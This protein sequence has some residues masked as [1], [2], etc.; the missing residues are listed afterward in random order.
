M[1]KM[2]PVTLLAALLLLSNSQLL[3]ARAAV[4]QVRH[5]TRESTPTSTS[6]DHTE[7]KPQ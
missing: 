6:D 7:R 2:N 1:N 4:N 5:Q 3:F